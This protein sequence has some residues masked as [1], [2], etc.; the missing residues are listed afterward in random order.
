MFFILKYCNICQRNIFFSFETGWA[1][2][3]FSPSTQSCFTSACAGRLKGEKSVWLFHRRLKHAINH[4]GFQRSTAPL[5]RSTAWE[6][7]YGCTHR[8]L[9]WHKPMCLPLCPTPESIRRVFQVS[10]RFIQAPT[11]HFRK[12]DSEYAKSSE[13]WV[14]WKDNACSTHCE[15]SMRWFSF[16]PCFCCTMVCL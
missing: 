8:M 2:F 6:S 4:S 10:T 14:S 5:R 15:N 1:D 7:F 12:L 9:I 16:S 11:E 13:R 3:L